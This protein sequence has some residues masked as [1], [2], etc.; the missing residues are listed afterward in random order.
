MR[1]LVQ[2]LIDNFD[3]FHGELSKFYM[4]RIFICDRLRAQSKSIS[5]FFDARIIYRKLHIRRNIIS[6]CNEEIFD[7]LKI[8][9]VM[10][11]KSLKN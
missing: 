3:Q 11:K 5:K 10:L 7:A 8:S 4:N 1:N 6:Y 9:V 2:N